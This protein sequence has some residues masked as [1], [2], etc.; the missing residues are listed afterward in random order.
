[1][2]SLYLSKTFGWRHFGVARRFEGVSIN[3]KTLEEGNLFVPLKGSKTDGHLFLEEATGRG[4]AGFFFERGKFPHGP[5]RRLLKRAFALEVENALFALRQTAALKR[6]LFRGKEVIAVTGTAGKTTLKELL[7]HLLALVGFTQKSLG[8]F[9]SRVG[10]PVSLASAD[11]RADYWVFELGASE[12]GNLTEGGKLLRP[13]LAVLTSL[14]KAHLEGFKNFENLSVAKGEVFLPPSVRK[15]VLPG[16]FLNLYRST[17][18]DKEI[19]T[20]GGEVS[21]Y[22]FRPDGRT[23]ILFEGTL[24]EVPLLGEGVVRGVEAAAAVLKA[25]GLPAA[26]VLKEGLPTFR[27]E[28]GRMQPLL[29]RG[30]LVV[31]DSY[32]ANPLSMRSA[33]ETLVRVEGYERRVAVL[34][35]MLELGAESRRE[36]EKLGDLLEKLPINEVYLFG[37]E[38]RFACDRVRSKPCRLFTDKEE[39]L[40]TLKRRE[41]RRGTV[42][43]IKGSRGT[44]MEEVLEAFSP[45]LEGPF[46][47]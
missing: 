28:R 27:G 2:F 19:F 4:A 23:E 37:E 6:D 3:S 15:A 1:M 44:R 16:R 30:F 9:N 17:L 18:G 47:P 14:G 10:L 41:P 13:T 22:R 34:G 29:G 31:D 12:R 46:S 39:L 20:F 5:P 36:H 25:L 33:L 45:F 24:L 35:Q 43:L 8:N 42:Y 7:A 21:K 26:E 11:E 40:K 38:M 32:N